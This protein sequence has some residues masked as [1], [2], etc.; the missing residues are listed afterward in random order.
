M[1]PG[2]S[3]AGP[4][5]RLILLLLVLLAFGLRLYHLDYQ[6]LWRDEMDAILFA[7]Q[8]LG[9]LLALF[10]KP[11]HNGPLYYLILH[12]WVRLAGD[13]EFSVRFPSLV[14]GVLGV[15]LVYLVGRLWLGSTASLTAAT[16]ATTS[17]YLVWYGQEGKMYTLVLLLS[18]LSTYVYLMALERNR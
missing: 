18:L 15:P 17:P 8:E 7:R 3:G 1:S 6:S 4:S 9:Q 10:V 2:S 12:G 14:C 5:P 11:G 13:S 16:L